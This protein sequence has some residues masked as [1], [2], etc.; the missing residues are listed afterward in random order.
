VQDKKDR[1]ESTE[2][3]LQ[4]RDEEVAASQSRVLAVQGALE[5]ARKDHGDVMAQHN[6]F[7]D[8]HEAAVRAHQEREGVL[9]DQV[10]DVVLGAT[11]AG[12]TPAYPPTHL[13]SSLI[14]SPYS[15]NNEP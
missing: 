8:Q 3:K 11:P 9:Q 13:P 6:E 10:K 5:R 4:T 2:R 1:R 14:S 7:V 15:L 12:E